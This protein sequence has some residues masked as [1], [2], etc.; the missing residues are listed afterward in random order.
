MQQSEGGIRFFSQVGIQPG[1]S[2]SDCWFG[3]PALKATPEGDFSSAVDRAAEFEL[4]DRIVL[5]R[6]SPEK[7]TYSA[8]FR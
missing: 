6:F 8:N 4:D 5:I 2:I 7:S 3:N 1:G